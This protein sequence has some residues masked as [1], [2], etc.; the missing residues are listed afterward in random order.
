[1]HRAHG[2]GFEA[3]VRSGDAGA[4]SVEVL[5]CGVLVDVED[6]RDLRQDMSNASCRT[7]TARSGGVSCSHH[8]QLGQGHRLAA[9]EVSSGPSV[10]GPVMTGSGSH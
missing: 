2:A 9:I 7:S 10:D 4:G 1:M 3:L 8:T 5:T 6:V